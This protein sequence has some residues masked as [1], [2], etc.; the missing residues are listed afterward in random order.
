MILDPIETKSEFGAVANPDPRA[1]T[2]HPDDHPPVPCPKKY[3]LT[4]CRV[5]ALLRAAIPFAAHDWMD[6]EL[7][8]DNCK[9]TK[10]S[11]PV[12]V[13]HWRA[14]RI[15]INDLASWR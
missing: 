14:L 2:C 10:H 7:E 15:A 6:A 4:H 13:G 5:A 3:A 12:T 8:D 1:C 11:G 9:L